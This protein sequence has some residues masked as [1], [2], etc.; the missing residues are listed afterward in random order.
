MA[1]VALFGAFLL[2][3]ATL[4]LVA[5]LRRMNWRALSIFSTVRRTFQVIRFPNLTRTVTVRQIELD[6][7]NVPVFS[8]FCEE[9][10]VCI[11]DKCWITHL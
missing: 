3:V 1:V 5:R 6:V 10:P 7:P 8:K 2:I 11:T 9:L 4:L